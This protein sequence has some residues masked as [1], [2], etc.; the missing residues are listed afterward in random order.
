MN[1]VVER[2]D[3]FE[4]VKWIIRGETDGGLPF[5]RPATQ[6]EVILW[7]SLKREEERRAKNDII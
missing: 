4:G 5:C 7:N 1:F 6:Q 3:M 2:S